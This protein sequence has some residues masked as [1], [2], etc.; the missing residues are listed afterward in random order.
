MVDR[1]LLVMTVLL[2]LAASVFALVTS[3]FD[4]LVVAIAVPFFVTSSYYSLR[5]SRWLSRR[6]VPQPEPP[7][8]QEPTPS[9]TQR[10]EHAQQ[11]RRRRRRK[12]RR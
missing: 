5:I 1:Q 7:P 12:S 6:V 11:R 10:P 9:T 3:G 4:W 2:S 8:V